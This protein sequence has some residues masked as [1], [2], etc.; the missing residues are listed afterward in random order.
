MR[1]LIVHNAYRH[2]GGEDAV[3]ANEKALLES[4]GHDVELLLVSNDSIAGGAGA[5]RAAAGTI[6]SRAGRNL[7]TEA[8]RRF[9]PDVLHVH[10]HFPLISPSLF[11]ATSA[12]RVP[13][14]WTLHN[15]RVTCA[16]G[17][18]FRDGRPCDDCV[19]RSPVSGII[20]RCYR[21]SLPGSAVVAAS[22]AWH[23]ARR[24][25]HRKVGC[26]IALSN[27]SRAKFIE[28]GIPRERLTVKPNFVPDPGELKAGKR[29]GAVFVGRLSPE[30]GARLLIRAWRDIHVPLTIV[31]DGPDLATLRSEAPHVRFTGKRDRAAVAEAIAGAALLIAPSLCYENFPM[32]LAEAF[33]LGTPVLAPNHGACRSIVRDGETGL[34]FAAGDEVALGA[35]VRDGFSAP[36]RLEEMGRAARTYYESHL[37]PARSLALL[38]SIYAAARAERS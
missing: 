15:Y 2:Y 31:G 3:A 30:K 1:I 26:F 5:A 33:A 28:A 14:V 20:H 22:I 21:G 38:E 29:T 9:S 35:A 13:S 7:V 19:G 16:N 8:I 4:A 12:A 37:T 36:A 6:Y 23:H 27:F 18:L 24:T 32:A 17:L 34:L 25:W 11:D 10:N